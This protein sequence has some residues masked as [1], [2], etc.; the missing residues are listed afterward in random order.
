MATKKRPNEKWFILAPDE[1]WQKY[2][3]PQ[4]DSNEPKAHDLLAWSVVVVK[5]SSYKLLFAVKVGTIEQHTWATLT[6][7]E[8]AS[9]QALGD[10]VDVIL[11]NSAMQNVHMFMHQFTEPFDTEHAKGD[12]R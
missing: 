1:L 2:E 5:T 3:T 12:V 7:W 8:I 11:E 4:D 10:H 9:L 6:R